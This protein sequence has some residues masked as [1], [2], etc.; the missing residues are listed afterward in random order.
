MI[1]QKEMMRP[2]T[3]L[4]ALFTLAGCSSESV[5]DEPQQPAGPLTTISFSADQQQEETVTRAGGQGLETVLTGD[6]TFRVWGYKNDGYDNNTQSYTSYQTVMPN[7]IVNWAANTAYTTT[8]NT[9]DWEY[10]GQGPDQTIKYWDW[11]AAAYRFFGYAIGNATDDPPTQPV[12]VTGGTVTTTSGV[13]A[14][15]FSATVDASTQP[16]RDAAPHFTRLWFSTGALPQYQDKQFGHPVQ[17]QFVKPYAR[18]RFMFTIVEGVAATRPDIKNFSFHPTSLGSFI[19]T[20]G[21]VT[22]SYPLT[23]TATQE[24]WSVSNS[25]A[26]L[27][28][29]DIDYYEA[30]VPAVTP[31][32]NLPTTWPNTPQHWYYV[33][34]TSSQGS[35]TLETEVVTNELKTVVVP[36][37]YMSWKAGYEYTYKFKITESGGITLDIIQVGVNGWVTKDTNIHQVYNW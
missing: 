7:F 25:T 30:P 12:T 32:D 21:T 24:T 3:A 37:E 10:V 16:T 9:N 36:A 1:L 33:L 29:F 5:G 22:V 28:K 23:G 19:S 15:K 4:F 11:S 8:S 18:V 13:A 2:L 14:V 31:T 34:P 27:D 26:S 20:A 6:K 35:Y 17:L